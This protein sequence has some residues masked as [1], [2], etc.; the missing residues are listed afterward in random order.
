MHPNQWEGRQQFPESTRNS[1]LRPQQSSEM[2]GTGSSRVRSCHPPQREI[3]PHLISLPPATS[4]HFIPFLLR[5]QETPLVDDAEINDQHIQSVTTQLALL[6]QQRQHLLVAWSKQLM[7]LVDEEEAVSC[8][9]MLTMDAKEGDPAVLASGELEG[10]LQCGMLIAQA[11][12]G[13]LSGPLPEVAFPYFRRIVSMLMQIIR[14]S[15]ASEASSPILEE[16]LQKHSSYLLQEVLHTLWRWS[17]QFFV[18]SIG[19]DVDGNEDPEPPG[20]GRAENEAKTIKDGEWSTPACRHRASGI[21]CR[22]SQ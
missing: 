16:M 7:L 20:N 9:N 6:Q 22:V 17:S 14:S 10:D 12:N 19:G 5:T 4:P 18:A 13:T 1:S 3:H 15:H 2:V 21:P 8:H 11:L